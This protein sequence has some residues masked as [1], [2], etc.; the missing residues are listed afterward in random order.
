MIKKSLM[1]RLLL[2]ITAML[3]LTG[4]LLLERKG[5]TLA[6]R[7]ASLAMLKA[8]TQD[9][10]AMQMPDARI[11]VARNGADSTEMAFSDTL[12]DVLSEMRL[13]YQTIDIS[14]Q[15]LPDLSNVET[16]LYCSQS[17]AP[18]EHDMERLSAWLDAG[19]R[20]GVL[21]TPADDAAFR[22][23]YRKFGIIEYGYE[24]VN[25]TSLRYVSGLLP[26]WGDTLFSENGA[27][28]DYALS[29]RLQED[30]TVHIVTGDERALPLLWERPVGKGRVVVFNATLMFNKGG[31]G[32]ALSA[33]SALEDALI[34][35]IINAGMVF[36][37]DFPAPQPEG[38]NDQLRQDYGYDIQG[39][40]RNHWWPDMKRL[41]WDYHL[42]YTGVL[43]QTYNDN[44]TGPFNAQGVDGVL[45]KYYASELLHSGGELGLHGY[46]HMP[47]CPPG[48]SD[49]NYNYT[50]WPST[51][52]MAQSM[53][54]LSRYGKT[55]F[56]DAS[57]ATYVPPSNYLSDIGRQTLIAALP[58]IKVLS[59]LYLRE[60]GVDALIQEF[61]EAGDGT[62]DLPRI[63]SGFDVDDFMGLVL[64][65]ELALHGVY[66]HFI[67]PDDI[68]DTMRSGNQNWDA[69]YRAFR[70]KIQAISQAYPFLRF[71]T[72]SEGAAAVQRYARLNV[73]RS[74]DQ[75]G[76]TLT[77]SPFYDEAWFALRTRAI[78]QLVRGGE[79]YRIAEGFYWIKANEPVIRVEWK[80]AP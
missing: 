73:A 43:I 4:V 16:L 26:L 52:A 14:R 68:L 45:Q 60:A 15:K 70:E 6:S 71:M 31:R 65:Q 8:S 42:R 79:I 7:G 5:M 80:A 66:S 19:G 34:Y 10:E 13:P 49:G 1:I 21:M 11:I 33:L 46:N 32:Y 55:L 20:F 47:L 3:L 78:P 57:F 24:Y 22:I 53:L 37:D 67:H 9:R 51:L 18:L 41:S 12:T 74:L 29:V 48:F 25:Y 63:T 28:T 2:P 64:A 75:Q 56:L 54:E 50:P 38:F 17:L 23:L 39:F 35:P 69:L 58:D 77:L 61:G 36:I 62:V 30:C 44:V 72:A 76:M 27:L 40:F 59:G